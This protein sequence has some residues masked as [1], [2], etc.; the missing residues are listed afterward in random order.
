MW[1]CDDQDPMRSPG[2]LETPYDGIDQDCDD[3]DLTDVDGDGFDGGDGPDCDD[4]RADVHPEIAEIWYD[5]VD[6][7]CD[8]ADDFDADGDGLAV[9]AD[10]DDAE[11]AV[12]A[13]PEPEADLPPKDGTG[14]CATVPG[15]FAPGL[16][17]GLGLLLLTRRR[18]R[19]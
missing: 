15:A 7:D 9:D 1:D 13:C 18:R 11:P 19:R 4:E 10:C 5:G 12:L 14:G 8:G 2:G 6:Q 16:L 17:G 3:A